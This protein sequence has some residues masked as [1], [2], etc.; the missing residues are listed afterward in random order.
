MGLELL[1]KDGQLYLTLI[2]MQTIQQHFQQ[3]D[4]DPTDIELESVAKPGVNIVATRP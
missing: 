4:R 1:S 3:L 2:E